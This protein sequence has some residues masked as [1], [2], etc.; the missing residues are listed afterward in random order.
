MFFKF[1]ISLY[2][3]SGVRCLRD[4]IDAQNKHIIRLAEKDV[5]FGDKKYKYFIMQSTSGGHFPSKYA[6]AETALNLFQANI[7]PILGLER[8][9]I[10]YD[11]LQVRSCARGVTAQNCLRMAAPASNMVLVYGL[12]G[13]Y[14]Q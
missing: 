5:F 1:F 13:M 10:E 8:D 7:I 3:I 11:I 9:G 12:G 2:A 4:H 14:V 6:H